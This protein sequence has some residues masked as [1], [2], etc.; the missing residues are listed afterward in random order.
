M[1]SFKTDS[2]ELA[3]QISIA[4]FLVFVAACLGF[5]IGEVAMRML[6]Q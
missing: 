5:V 6:A 2:A 4:F 3:R 1:K